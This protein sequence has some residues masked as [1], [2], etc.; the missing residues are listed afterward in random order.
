MRKLELRI[1]HETKSG[2]AVR[3]IDQTLFLSKFST[4]FETIKG[5]L[6]K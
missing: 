5:L 4:L 6:E 3:V 2:A 1:V